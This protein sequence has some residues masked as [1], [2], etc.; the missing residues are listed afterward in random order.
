VPK[1]ASRIEPKPNPAPFNDKVLDVIE[2]QLRGYR[3]VLD[4]FAGTGKGV[5]RM[6][7][8]GHLAVGVELEPEW[9]MQSELVEVGNALELRWRA[10]TFD[11]VFTS[12]TYGNRMA[13]HHDAQEVCKTCKGTGV[14]SNPVS[15][16]G[17]KSPDLICEKC[18]GEGKRVYK[19]HTYKHYLGRDPSPESSAVMQWGPEYRMFHWLAWSEVA[20]VLKPKRPGKKQGR[21]VLNISDHIRKGEVQHVSDW[22]ID[23]IKGLGFKKVRNID[24]STERLLHGENY[25]LRVECEHVV[26]F[27]KVA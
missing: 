7:D 1:T 11:A 20:R 21:F 26:V 22:H 3:K 18:G 2:R 17:K 16:K 4:P 12:C 15:F 27:D 14:V 24:V 8:V 5:D 25:E 6:A 9:A 19:R 23:T 13:D 10:S